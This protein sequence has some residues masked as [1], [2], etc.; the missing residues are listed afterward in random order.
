MTSVGSKSYLKEL[1]D[2][3]LGNQ[4]TKKIN[5][6]DMEIQETEDGDEITAYREI[7]EKLGVVAVRLGTRPKSM[8][9][10]KYNIDE[11]QGRAHL[12]YRY[13]DEIFRYSIYMN[14]SD[15][16]LSQKEEDEFKDSFSI[17]NTQQEIIVEEYKVKSYKKSRFTA[18]FDYQDVHYQLKGVM[19]KKEIKNI[20]KN[21]IYLDEIE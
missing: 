13:G 17:K 15:S 16:S 19:T 18:E 1:L 9:L 21:L 7:R 12:F 2:G 8:Y 10:E 14:N 6:K 20:I 3:V 4:N 5:V 11:R